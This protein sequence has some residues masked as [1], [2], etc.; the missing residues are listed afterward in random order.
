MKKLI[1]FAAVFLLLASA[2]SLSVTAQEEEI[3]KEQY[4][5]SGA[6]ELYDMLTD[7]AKSLMDELGASPESYDWQKVLQ[8]KNVFEIIGDL[9]RNGAKA[10]FSAFGVMVVML[11]AASVVNGIFSE[12]SNQVSGVMTYISLICGTLCTVVPFVKLIEG[13][14]T[15]LKGCSNFV[16]GFIPIYIGVLTSMGKPA[17]AAASSSVMLCVCQAVT[18]LAGNFI[19]P[20]IS[21]Y[22]ALNITSVSGGMFKTA[23]LGETLKTVS[24]WSLSFLM[25][26]FLGIMGIQTTIGGAADTAGMRTAKFVVSSTVPIVGVAVSEAI[27]TVAGSL[28]LLST[29]TGMFAVLSVVLIFLPVLCQLLMWKLAV[30]LLCGFARLLD[31]RDVESVTAAINSTISMIIGITLCI[32]IMF[33]VS[34][35]IIISVGGR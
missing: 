25:T 21:V 1:I 4:Q 28:K 30:L 33:V 13:V 19:L 34:L 12:K 5:N 27:S 6:D 24:I 17:T 26:V 8:P 14:I 23:R 18:Q 16:L 22:L 20:V 15:A 35:A 31:E 9:I 29:T 10:P 7:D 2:S 32:G 3:F 11:V